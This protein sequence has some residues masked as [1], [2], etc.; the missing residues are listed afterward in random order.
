MC[1]SLQIANAAR[2][3]CG[4]ARHHE[5]RENRVCRAM[6]ATTCI[7]HPAC[8]KLKNA[9]RGGRFWTSQPISCACV[10]RRLNSL[11]VLR[12]VFDPWFCQPSSSCCSALSSVVT[13][14]PRCLCV[15][16][17]G[18]AS[19]LGVTINNTR[20]LELP[21][22]CSVKTPPASQ[23]KCELINHHDN[24]DVGQICHGKGELLHV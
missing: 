16:L 17:G 23:C 2:V 22:V 13:S 18:G 4:R 9:K 6:K 5:R 11:G 19:S 24:S 10:N 20:A 8:Y 14:N 21:G 1:P 3:V 15:V 12:R 7:S